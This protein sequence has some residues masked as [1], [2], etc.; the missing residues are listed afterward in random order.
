MAADPAKIALAEVAL[1]YTLSFSTST[2]AP[3]ADVVATSLVASASGVQ[4]GAAANLVEVI[5]AGS[6]T[7]VTPVVQ[8]LLLTAASHAFLAALVASLSGIAV[9]HVLSENISNLAIVQSG[10]VAAASA[11]TVAIRA[12]T[13]VNFIFNFFFKII[14]NEHGLSKQIIFEVKIFRIFYL[15]TNFI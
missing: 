9:A 13:A 3:H 15:F 14:I 4:R 5:P 12:A 2:H 1:K 8:A 10:G 11:E 6:Q 7:V